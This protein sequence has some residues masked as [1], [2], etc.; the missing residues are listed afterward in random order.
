[1]LEPIAAAV[2]IL[3]GAVLHFIPQTAGYTQAVWA[4]GLIVVGAPVVWRTVVGMMHGK[5]AADVVAML[6]IITAVILLQPLAGLIVVLMQTGGESIERYAEGRASTAVRELEKAAPQHAHRIRDGVLE[7]ITPNQIAVDDGLVVRPGELIPCDGL[8]TDGLSHVDTSR[9][10]GEAVPMRASNGTRVAS[11]SING[12][13]MLTIR[14]TAL[15]AE[16]QYEKIV[17]LVRTAQA[18]RSPLQRLADR[19]AVWFTPLAL[20]LCA[21]TFALTQNWTR[22]LAVLVVATPCPLIL[23]TPVA[24]IGGVNRAARRHVV[25]RTGGALEQLG[26]IEV[27]V[28][29]KT[30]TLTVGTPHVQNVVPAAGFR[31][32]EVLAAAAA[33]ERGSN[34]LLAR[35]VVRSAED[36]GLEPD[37]AS[38]IVETPGRGVEGRVNGSYVVVGSLSLVE[39]RAQRELHEQARQL[40]AGNGRGLQS[41]VFVGDRLTGMIEFADPLRPDLGTFFHELRALGVERSVLLS[42]DK[43]ENTLRVARQIGVTEAYGDLL[44][45]EKYE[46]VRELTRSA[47][48][49]MV[50]DGT[51][52]AP[53]LQAATVGVALAGHGGGITAESADAVVLVDDLSRVTDAIRISRRTLKIA[54]Q[55]IWTGLALSSIAMVFAA[56]G[57]IPPVAGAMIQ[58]AIDVAVIINALRASL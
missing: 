56:A 21:L 16:S 19:Y 48:T 24:I 5:F 27:A 9:L 55:S 43:T 14:A 31:R 33:V 8:V 29:D 58:E 40:G 15:A 54:K 57:Y 44:P 51:N 25:L 38:D 18:S 11:G 50:G 2:V 53:A 7:E 32:D 52:D 39:E 12:E 47:R 22:V 30:G 6:A 35:T 23:A 13:G 41:Y 20:V 45:G 28:F 49:M 34:H 3:L 46:F 42:G 17:T 1:M 37:L 10:T 26:K 36:A 4:L